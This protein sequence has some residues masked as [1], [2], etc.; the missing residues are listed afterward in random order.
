MK[1]RSRM[2]SRIAATGPSALASGTWGVPSSTCPP[3]AA[4]SGKLTTLVGIMAGIHHTH[5]CVSAKAHET[6]PGQSYFEEAG[7]VIEKGGLAI[8]LE[9]L[10]FVTW[11]CKIVPVATAFERC[12]V[13]RS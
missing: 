12:N 2:C 6:G 11:K 4:I 3:A 13:K 1:S 7:T 9:A 5:I 10:V 8:V